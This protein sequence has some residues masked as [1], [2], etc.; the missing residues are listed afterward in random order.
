MDLLQLRTFE[1]VEQG[2]AR[3]RKML[4]PRL[5]FAKDVERFLDTRWGP[6]VRAS[7]AEVRDVEN[8]RAFGGH[9]VGEARRASEELDE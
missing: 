5:A 4:R 8:R 6:E 1:E 7:E 3:W 2:G 9:A